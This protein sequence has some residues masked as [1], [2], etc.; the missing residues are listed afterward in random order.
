MNAELEQLLPPAVLE[1]AELSAAELPWAVLMRVNFV[2]GVRQRLGW[3]GIRQCSLTSGGLTAKVAGRSGVFGLAREHVSGNESRARAEFGLYYFPD[4]AEELLE[5]FSIAACQV[6][7][8]DDFLDQVREFTAHPQLLEL[9]GIGRVLLEIE[10]RSRQINLGLVAAERQLLISADGIRMRG[11]S[12]V[13]EVVAAGAADQDLPAWAIALEFF[14]VLAGSFSFCL[15]TGPEQLLRWQ[16]AGKK[17]VYSQSG[18]YAESPLPGS[19]EWFL[20]LVWGGDKISAAAAGF[21]GLPELQWCQ[22]AP[23]PA[24]YMAERWWTAQVPGAGFSVDKISMGIS[25]KPKLLVLTGFLGAGKTSFLNHFI[26]YQASRNAFV[27]IIQNEIGARGLDSR[28]VGQ[29]YAVTDMDEGCVCCTLAGNLKL[30]LGEILGGYQPDFVVIETTGLANPANFLSE[31]CELS[32]RLEF[33]SVTTV[34][35]AA[36]HLAPFKDYQVARDQ[37]ALADVLLVNKASRLDAPQLAE[38]ERYLRQLNPFAA[39]HRADHGDFSPALLYGVNFA[40]QMKFPQE[41][42]CR[43]GCGGTHLDDEIGSALVLFEQCPSK[44]RF[45]AATASFPAELLRAKGIVQFAEDTEPQV[46]Q[47]VPG[48]QTLSP[49]PGTDNG[50]RFVVLIGKNIDRVSTRLN[51]C[52]SADQTP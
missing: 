51:A 14:R 2:P 18:A 9:F 23:L 13:R 33:C 48:E 38:L 29:H 46:Y 4:P 50:E 10:P 16:R 6:A 43:S 36:R 37:A 3:R 47:Y 12:G 21:P 44:Q 30:A 17:A 31:V 19:H 11:P 22:G 1:N 42:A 20:T 32:D 39:L 24:A 40:G 8:Q 45:F 5:A 25:E 49:L 28:M 27:A 7:L 34:V 26:E 41:L 52:C 15:Q 35:D